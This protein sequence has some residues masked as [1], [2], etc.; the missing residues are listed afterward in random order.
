MAAA[1]GAGP[2][3]LVVGASVAAA[4]AS[5][6]SARICRPGSLDASRTEGT[7]VLCERGGLGRVEK[8]EA[9]EQADGVGMVLAN[10]G[11]GRV[12][13]DLHS[14]PT[15]HVGA[16][17]ARSLRSWRA[18]HPRARITLSPL[19]VRSAAPVVTPWSSS[20]D[21]TG[22]VVKPDLVGP[23]VGVLGAVPPSVRDARW[24]FVTG[25]SA[26]TA[27]TSGLALRLLARHDWS[28]DAVRSALA[29]GAASVAG[30]PSVLR[31]GAGRPRF[32]QAD[33]P[34]LAYLVARGDYRTWLEG[35]LDGELNTPSILLSGDHTTATRTI[36]NMG[37]RAATF[38][39]S[40]VGF[41]DHSVAVTPAAVR[42]RPGRSATFRVTVSGPDRAVP[43]DDGWV[44][45]ESA[46]GTRA[47][48]PVALTR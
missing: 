38:S 3:R 25:T 5:R 11:P 19:G 29:T 10:V 12:E 17:A 48:I 20:G 41:T 6:E 26:A 43:L 34:G 15:V 9:V 13:S 28:A 8:S 2:A 46:D 16:E 40:A 21:P 42:L 1:R 7:I 14:V 44:L 30:R 27:W 23:A 45:W 22:T 47:R 24:D 4:G 32:A 36:T 31:E 33:R 18:R 39:A 35:N 37:A